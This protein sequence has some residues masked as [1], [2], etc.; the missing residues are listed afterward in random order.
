MGR[1]QGRNGS[2]SSRGVNFCT[3]LEESGKTL[4][5]HLYFTRMSNGLTS[6]FTKNLS[7]SVGLQLGQAVATLS[8]IVGRMTSTRILVCSK[9]PSIVDIW[10]LRSVNISA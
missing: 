10:W 5:R 3:V 6:L 4:N 7:V 9:L 1:A 8:M 2:D